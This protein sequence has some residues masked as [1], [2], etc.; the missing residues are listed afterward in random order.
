MVFTTS[1]EKTVVGP[2]RGKS[3]EVFKTIHKGP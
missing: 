1:S 2:G 3:Q